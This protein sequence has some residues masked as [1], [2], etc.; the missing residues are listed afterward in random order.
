MR[1]DSNA[2]AAG[3][4]FTD[5][6]YIHNR[7][8]RVNGTRACEVNPQVQLSLKALAAIEYAATATGFPAAT[9]AA[10]RHLAVRDAAVSV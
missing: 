1:K 4:G 5:G 3:F 2:K 7:G 8:V 10:E 6:L 9:D